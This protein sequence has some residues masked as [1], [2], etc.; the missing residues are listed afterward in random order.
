M[1]R[2]LRVPQVLRVAQVRSLSAH[3]VLTVLRVPLDSKV[4]EV[5]LTKLRVRVVLRVLK[6]LQVLRVQGVH[7]LSVHVVLTVLR[8]LQVFKVAQVRR[9]TRQVIV[10]VRG[11]KAQL[12]HKV[13][14]AQGVL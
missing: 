13:Q 2:V 4:Q 8:V 5:I 3:V 11:H 7:S 10:A 14:P 6:V 9:T 12:D 1:L